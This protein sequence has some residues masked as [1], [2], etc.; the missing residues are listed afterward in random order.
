M[1]DRMDIKTVQ[2][3][4]SAENQGKGRAGQ[5]REREGRNNAIMITNNTDNVDRHR[6]RQH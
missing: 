6:R 1:Y 3:Q 5:G 2:G 4:C